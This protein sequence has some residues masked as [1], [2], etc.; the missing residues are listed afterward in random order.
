[1]PSR[2][3]IFRASGRTPRQAQ[4]EYDR[5]RGPDRQFY[6]SR[7]WRE[8]RRLYLLEHPLCV[9]C[10]AEGRDEFAVEVHHVAKR[11]D[12]PDLAYDPDNVAGLCKGHH[13][14][15]TRAGK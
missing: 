10:Q 15:R 14:K 1:M 11:K 6:S 12:R 3:P 13:S 4:A 9:D 8:F 2:P 5:S 7:Q